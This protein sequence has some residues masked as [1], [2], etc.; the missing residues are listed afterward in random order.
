M[1]CVKKDPYMKPIVEDIDIGGPVVMMRYLSD[2]D[3][4]NKLGQ[5]MGSGVS[6]EID[7][8]HTTSFMNKYW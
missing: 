5:A 7:R 8:T 3:V 4:L 1:R 2:S 6:R